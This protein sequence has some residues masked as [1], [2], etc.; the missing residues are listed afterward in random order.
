MQAVHQL[1]DMAEHTHHVMPRF[2]WIHKCQDGFDVH[3]PSS[4]STCPSCDTANDD[5]DLVDL[6]KIK[7][8]N[9]IPG[10]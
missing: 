1:A 10:L 6:A 4:T 3:L 8:A 2:R 7:F 9:E 5:L